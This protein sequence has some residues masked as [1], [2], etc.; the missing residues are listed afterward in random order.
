MRLVSPAHATTRHQPPPS[1]TQG[2]SAWLE[3]ELG[4]FGWTGRGVNHGAVSGG[5]RDPRLFAP[6]IYM[7]Q[8]EFAWPGPEPAAQERPLKVE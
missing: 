3:Q 4:A 8:S 7:R 1:H 6:P 5:A 2:V